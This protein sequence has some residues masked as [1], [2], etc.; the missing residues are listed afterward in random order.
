MA[1]L[2]LFKLMCALAVLFAVVSRKSPIDKILHKLIPDLCSD[3]GSRQPCQLEIYTIHEGQV[4][5]DQERKGQNYHYYHASFM[6][7]PSKVGWL[8]L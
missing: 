2:S 7:Q 8:K 6:C 1:R 5:Q 3:R 4:H